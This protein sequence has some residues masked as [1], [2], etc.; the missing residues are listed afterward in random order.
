MPLSKEDT[1]K[2]PGGS[3][4]DAALSK[5]VADRPRNSAFDEYPILY[6]GNNDF[7]TPEKRQDI[8]KCNIQINDN[9]GRYSE[10]YML[11]AITFGEDCLEKVEQEETPV[12]EHQ[13][14]CVKKGRKNHSPV[15]IFGPY[16]MQMMIVMWLRQ[17]KQSCLKLRYYDDRRPQRIFY[18]RMRQ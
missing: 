10:D 17:R 7:F 8:R 14:Y 1:T 15:E 16:W 4:E 11:F 13:R 9:Q 2:S 6:S 12:H 5:P 18:S 3:Y